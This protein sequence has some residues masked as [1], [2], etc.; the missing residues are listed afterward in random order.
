M[1]VSPPRQLSDGVLRRRELRRRKRI[2]LLARGWRLLALLAAST[3]L[4]WL[5]LRHGWGL[6]DAQQVQ[7]TGAWGFSREDHR[8]KAMKW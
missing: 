2:S 7:V 3:G 5:L 4:G 1:S 6:R 8:S